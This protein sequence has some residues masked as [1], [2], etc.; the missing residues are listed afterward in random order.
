MFPAL[1]ADS[2]P[3]SHQA[4]PHFIFTYFL[5]QMHFIYPFNNNFVFYFILHNS[6]FHLYNFHAEISYFLCSASWAH[7]EV[8]VH[9]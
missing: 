1:Q 4:S 7:E 2:Q 6:D 9:R 3:L 5:F 8:L